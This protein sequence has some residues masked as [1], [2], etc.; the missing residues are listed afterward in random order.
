MKSNE[1]IMNNKEYLKLYFSFILLFMLIIY[2]YI[3]NI[4][5]YIFKISC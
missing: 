2:K 5:N 4:K 1:N 3:N